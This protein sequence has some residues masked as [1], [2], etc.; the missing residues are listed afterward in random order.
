[1]L[2]HNEQPAEDQIT[3]SQDD[4][5]VLDAILEA[6]AYGAEVGPL[7][8]GSSQRAEKI[9]DILGLLE[10][11][12]VD[13]VPTDLT[14]RTIESIQNAR[15]RARFAEQIQMLKLG[16][17]RGFNLN[18]RQAASAAAVII[19][20]LSLLLPTLSRGKNESQRIACAANMAMMGRGLASYA[21]ANHGYLPRAT[22][23]P[24][25]LDNM[26]LLEH[27]IY[28]RVAYP[29]PRPNSANLFLL[30][31]NSFVDPDHAFC[32][33]L[34]QPDEL[35]NADNT[36]FASADAVPFSYQNQMTAPSLQ[37]HDMDETHAV[38]ADRNPL[39]VIRNGRFLFDDQ[40]SPNASSDAHA[41]PGQNVLTADLSVRWSVRPVVHPQNSIE[42]NIWVAQAGKLLEA[43]EE[44][45]KHDSFLTP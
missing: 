4:A 19:I 11:M 32:A 6:R 26:A 12:A 43:E 16:P 8:P 25:N 17:D 29:K 38:L 23:D 15:Q 35:I 3:I 24:M 2:D 30:L 1:M 31:K 40:R 21:D 5:G 22:H 28:P 34:G 27:G 42:D 13:A 10:T 37:I 20:G 18:L 45:A 44:A 9:R 14:E 7:P 41:M 39:F 36:D 33:G